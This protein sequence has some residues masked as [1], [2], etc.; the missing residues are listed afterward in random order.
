MAG[1]KTE[2][3]TQKKLK[4]SAEKGTSYKNRDIVAACILGL[5]MFFLSTIS[6][7]GVGEL[8]KDFINQGQNI[9]P[10]FAIQ[11]C[12]KL[13]FD[14]A[15]PFIGVCIIATVIPSLFQSKL[16]LAFK[17]IKFDFNAI[18]PVSGFSKIFN[19]K[20]IK[21]LIKA[22]L[23]LTVFFTVLLLFYKEFR[24]VILSLIYAQAASVSAIWLKLGIKL[25]LL[26]L[27]AFLFIILLDALAD[28]YFYIKNLRMDKHEVKQEY[29]EQESSA[30]VKSRRRDLQYELL[31]AQDS[32]DVDQSNFILANPTHI[33]IGIYINPNISHLPF[34][35]MVKTDARA[36]A[37][38]AYAE[39]NHVPVIRD[40]PLTRRL[41]KTVK[42]YTFIPA[43]MIED[44]LRIVLWLQEVEMAYQAD[45]LPVID[46]PLL[47]TPSVV[48][49]SGEPEFK[50]E[51]KKS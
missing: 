12:T 34:V 22:L 16:I 15:L 33:A 50:V 38:I 25:I 43:D 39:K 28:Y 3:P 24:H 27:C 20:T 6:L 31:S 1:E 7:S 46:N 47:I 40:K 2:E 49:D 11:Q 30:E 17:A 14:L 41:Y 42:P 5:G 8:F 45:A 51:E 13:F 29:K 48:P 9:N 10:D 36:L 19:M 26:C 44:V 32:N 21:E 18:N 37:V 35:S 23:Y 4:D